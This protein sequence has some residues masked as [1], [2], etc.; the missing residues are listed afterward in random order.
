MFVRNS[1]YRKF[2]K[3]KEGSFIYIYIYIYHRNTWTDIL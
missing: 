3:F 1:I 2:Y